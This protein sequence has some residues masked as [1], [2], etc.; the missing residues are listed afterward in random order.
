MP[1]TLPPL[2]PLHVFEVASRLGSFSRAA[3]ELHVTPS[4]ISRQIATL[5]T[6]LG[7]PLF[8]RE[9]GGVALTAAGKAYRQDIGP[10][11]ARIATATERLRR[12]GDR[13]P[14]RLRCYTVFALKWLV[15]RLPDFHAAHPG[16]EL[17]LSTAIP[18]V[19]FR[20]E[21]VDLAI[22]FGD[23]RWP[24][25]K[26]Q[27]ILA[28]RIQPVCAPSLLRGRAKVD[29]AALLARHRL[30]YARYRRNDWRD[31]LAARGLPPMRD[32]AVEMPMSLVAWEAAAAGMGIAMGQEALL[33]P[34]LAS[35][36]LVMPFA[37]PLCRPMGYFAVWP[38]DRPMQPRLRLFLAWLERQACVPESAR[39]RQP[40]LTGH[41]PGGFPEDMLP[42]QAS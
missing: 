24:E 26:S 5:E 21:P 17:T 14:L 15:P 42:N 39:A 10:A 9:A 29:P 3:E 35:S 38:E 1:R 27:S 41:G 20:E 16:V 37:A 23:G 12:S 40:A 4:A 28:D 7:Q 36:Q 31:W 11:F 25:L 2:N 6:W 22:Q 19:D 30:L 34:E 18:P 13:K 33:A 32:N 8:Q